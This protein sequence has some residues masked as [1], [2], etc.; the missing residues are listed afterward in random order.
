M[1]GGQI[2]LDAPK[3]VKSFGING[4]RIVAMRTEN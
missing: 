2:G 1:A 4:S 3:A